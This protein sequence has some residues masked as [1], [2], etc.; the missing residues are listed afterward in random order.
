M[1]EVGR[2][3]LVV[4][5]ILVTSWGCSAQEGRLEALRADPLATLVVDDATEIRTSES[6]GTDGPGKSAPSVI[7]R[8]FEIDEGPA[9]E[10]L[11]RLAERAADVGWEV[12]RDGAA[13]VGIR[14]LEG[15]NAQLR[16]SGV[17]GTDR[18]AIEIRS[19]TER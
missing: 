19:N 15:Y 10:I 1:A 9:S 18:I 8:T 5:G 17:T 2:R 3:L 12:T 13:Y 4:L 6:A 11:A 7:R 16:L 14:R